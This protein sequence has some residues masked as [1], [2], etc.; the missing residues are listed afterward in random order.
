MTQPQEL[1]EQDL[2]WIKEREWYFTGVNRSLSTPDRTMLFSILSWATGRT[3][4]P[5]GCGR[6]M[7]TAKETLWSLYLKQTTQP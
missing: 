4:T 1:R 2:N 7:T 5:S 3:Q 6:C